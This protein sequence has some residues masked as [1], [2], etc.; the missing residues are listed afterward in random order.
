MLELIK[1]TLLTGVGLAVLTKDKVEQLAHDLAE[2]GS[3]SEKEGRELLDTLLRRS[4][5]ARAEL[6][7]R[8]QAAVQSALERLDVPTRKDITELAARIDRL[9]QRPD[10]DAD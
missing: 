3:L 2:K 5:E 10:S 8:V 4:E 6:E 1:K 7:R 9:Q